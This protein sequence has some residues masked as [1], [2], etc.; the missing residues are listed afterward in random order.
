[1]GTHSITKAVRQADRDSHKAAVAVVGGQKAARGRGPEHRPLGS[2]A[3]S[4]PDE[5]AQCDQTGSLFWRK[6]WIPSCASGRPR[7]STMVWEAR[8]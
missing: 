6:A 7:L 4:S 5:A 3:P 8:W 1:M 2:G